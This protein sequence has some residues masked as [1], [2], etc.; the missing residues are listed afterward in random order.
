MKKTLLAIAAIA[1]LAA[2]GGNS[3][4]SGNEDTLTY[5]KVKQQVDSTDL[6]EQA[7]GVETSYEEWQDGGTIEWD[8]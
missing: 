8:N 7:A 4:Q 1:M 3:N 5:E 2:C 6:A